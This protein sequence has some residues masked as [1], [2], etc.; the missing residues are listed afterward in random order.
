MFGKIR[1]NDAWNSDIAKLK[2]E[3]NSQ[4]IATNVN[5]FTLERTLNE[6][7]FEQDIKY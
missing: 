3:L 6:Y 4:Q 1:F 7:D 5:P 2:E